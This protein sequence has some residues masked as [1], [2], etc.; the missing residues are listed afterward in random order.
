MLVDAKGSAAGVMGGPCRF[1]ASP[2][3]LGGSAEGLASRPGLG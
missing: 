2:G 3:S 1:Q